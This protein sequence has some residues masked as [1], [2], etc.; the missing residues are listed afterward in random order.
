MPSLLRIVVTETCGGIDFVAIG[1]AI[2][3]SLPQHGEVVLHADEENVALRFGDSGDVEFER[4]EKSLVGAEADTVEVD[5]APVVDS[6]E[7]EDS[8]F[9]CEQ[10]R[11]KIQFRAVKRGGG[12]EWRPVV[13]QI[14]CGPLAFAGENIGERQA[15][16]WCFFAPLALLYTEHGARSRDGGSQ[17]LQERAHARPESGQRGLQF[18]G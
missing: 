5:L 14:D 13:W 1:I 2:G 11:G 4:L 15:V 10:P 18:L 9:R 7:A 12:S 16:G 17:V 8:F 6:V 3:K